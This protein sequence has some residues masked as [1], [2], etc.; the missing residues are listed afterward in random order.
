MKALASFMRD[1]EVFWLYTPFDPEATENQCMVN[2]VFVGQTQGDIRQKLQKLEGFTGMNVTQL[3]E[4]VTKVY[5]NCDQ[6][7]KREADRRLR[8][9]ADLLGA[10]L[11]ERGTSIMRGRGHGHRQGRGQTGQRPKN[12]PRLDSD[13]CTQCKKKGHWKNECLEDN[14]GND[15]GYKTRRLPAKGYRIP[16]EPD[17]DL[18]G[19]AETEGYKD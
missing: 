15:R 3:L 2:M 1:S 11:T 17:A 7:A 16:K 18:L 4:V 13:Q 14:E 12:W 5:V 19:L 10:A 9:K 8:K 6:E